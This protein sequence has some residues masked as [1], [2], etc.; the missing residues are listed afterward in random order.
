[1]FAGY[2]IGLIFAIIQ[3]KRIHGNLEKAAP[4]FE[5]C[6][7]ASIIGARAMTAIEHPASYIENQ[8]KFLEIWTGG[9]GFWGG[10]LISL[11]AGSWYLRR[12]SFNVLKILDEL[13]I[14]AAML[15]FSV[16]R[17]GCFAA[18]DEF[19]KVSTL[20]WAITHTD[21]RSAIN[22]LFLGVP[23]H[24]LSIYVSLVSF[25]IFLI[26][27][28]LRKHKKY[29]GEIT[30]TVLILF[31]VSRFLLETL[32]SEYNITLLFDN[33]SSVQFVSILGFIGSLICIY[34]LYRQ[35]SSLE[36]KRTG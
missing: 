30:F 3:W 18:G 25:I 19:G 26:S 13:A 8:F 2:L 21:P 32:R 11:V 5:I 6:F 23:T 10:L 29:D 24:P 1:M 31:S 36:E 34:A 7:L 33:L 17:F 9:Y 4:F 12:H 28:R 35:Q 27:L 14:P 22:P 20:P 15:G 16:G